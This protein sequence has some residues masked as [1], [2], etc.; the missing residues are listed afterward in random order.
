VRSGVETF[1]VVSRELN[2]LDSSSAASTMPRR[3]LL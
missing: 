3:E 1:D 2:P